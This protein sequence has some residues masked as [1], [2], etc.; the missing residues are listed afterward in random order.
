MDIHEQA[1]ANRSQQTASIG[2][3]I[4]VICLVSMTC[5]AHGERCHDQ[6][7]A[8]VTVTI[9]KDETREQFD[10][11]TQDLK[12]AAA[13]VGAQAH[14]PAFAAYSAELAFAA[15]ISENAQSEEGDVYC[16]S[17][18]SVYV[19][20]SLKNPIIHLAR[21]LKDNH[22]LE[23]VQRRHWRE[24]ARA[25]AE[26]IDEFPFLSEFRDVVARSQPARANSAFAAKT[27]LTAA[28]HSDIER[29][30]DQLN[31]HRA[32]VQQTVDRQEA[33]ERLGAQIKNCST[34]QH[35]IFKR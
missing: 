25:D 9:S 12:R 22:C 11:T 16:A 20:I 29:L 30:M 24:H 8:D 15:D 4:A 14:R 33:I 26:A 28:I 2:L 34:S 18:T 21:E 19:T 32:A 13:S 7:A 27:Q 6:S 17:P 1:Q 23:A 35:V 31:E 3:S 10:V 5:A